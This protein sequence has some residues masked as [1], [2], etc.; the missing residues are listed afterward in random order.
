MTLNE[1]FHLIDCKLIYVYHDFHMFNMNDPLGWKDAE[2]YL[3][4]YGSREVRDFHYYA[5]GDFHIFL[6]EDIDNERR[7]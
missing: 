6:K 7:D 3:A 4:Y 5:S 2:D 1:V